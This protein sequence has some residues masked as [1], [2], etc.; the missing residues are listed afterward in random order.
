MTT[1]SV[2]ISIQSSFFSSLNLRFMKYILSLMKIRKAMINPNGLELR[3]II[4]RL[5]DID[6]TLN[7]FSIT[8]VSIRVIHSIA[9]HLHRLSSKLHTLNK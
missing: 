3:E 4:H 5:G 6:F 2:F 8:P 9:K 7:Q 1:L